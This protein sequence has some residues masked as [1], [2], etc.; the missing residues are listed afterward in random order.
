M[1]WTVVALAAGICLTEILNAL[2]PV[3]AEP[4]R[5]WFAS[6]GGWGARIWLGLT[7]LSIVSGCWFIAKALAADARQVQIVSGL[8]LALVAWHCL[9]GIGDITTARINS[10]ATQQLAG[11]LNG[12][13]APDFGYSS[14]CKEF[15]SNSYPLRQYLIAAIPAL[16]GGRSVLNAHLGF[17][18]PLLFGCLLCYAGMRAYLTR[19]SLSPAVPAALILGLF[20]TPHVIIY[21]RRFEQGI[22]P[23]A[24]TAA[25]LGWLLLYLDRPTPVRL[26][27]LTWNGCLLGATYTPA[28]AS[29]AMLMAFCALQA[30]HDFRQRRRERV[31]GW[32]ACLLPV[33]TTG[34]CIFTVRNDRGMLGLSTY[35]EHRSVTAA[36]SE[37]VR[38]FFAVGLPDPQAVH[39]DL[40]PPFFFIAPLLPLIVLYL[41]LGLTGRLGAVSAL[42]CAWVGSIIPASA[43]L[44]GTSSAPAIVQLHRG[45][46]ILPVLYF[47]MTWSSVRF[48]KARGRLGSKFVHNIIAL[49]L[50]AV[51]GASSIAFFLNDYWRFRDARM[52]VRDAIL[53]DLIERRES[54]EW[55]EQHRATVIVISN[56]YGVINLRDTTMYFLPETPVYISANRLPQVLS[57]PHGIVFYID[58][59]Y[60]QSHIFEPL[61]ALARQRET[62]TVEEAKRTQSIQMAELMPAMLGVATEPILPTPDTPG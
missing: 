23:L 8:A 55:P 1:K 54:P 62:I 56:N 28:L 46:I 44:A 6:A 39:A 43:L 37:A 2:L 5:P 50:T 36:L 3:T 33:L 27:G 29:W 34:L 19:D 12:W 4:S 45:M 21:L 20:A 32:L 11:G 38:A 14:A 30:V 7:V 24:F 31:V 51:F 61:V 53:S 60:L 41:V 59:S 49:L 22:L 13:K 10:E 52:T 9:W 57:F 16:L 47:G 15:I 42:I 48:L 26:A 17:A 40:A 58:S 35:V 18:L 25:A